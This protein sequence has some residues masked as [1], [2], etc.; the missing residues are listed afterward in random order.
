MKLRHPWP[1][2]IGDLDPDNLAPGGDRNRHHPPGSARPAV[3]DTVTEQLIHQQCGLIPARVPGAKHLED[4]R[5]GGTRPLR[6]PGKRHTLPDRPPS[7][8]RTRP[9]PAAPPRET[10]RAA[11]GRREMHAQLSPG[12]QAGTTGSADL[13]RGSSV[14]AAPSVAVRAKPT[15]PTGSAGSWSSPPERFLFPGICFHRRC[16]L[17]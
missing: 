12:R 8:H 7:H 13:V 14:V 9:S 5:A 15:A 16:V 1:A 11:G 10:S 4:E 2:A 6:P 17:T 3:P